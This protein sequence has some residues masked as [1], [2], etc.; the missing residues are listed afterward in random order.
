M[1]RITLSLL[2]CLPALA[3]AQVEYT[4]TINDLGEEVRVDV[5][6]PTAS[7]QAYLDSDFLR[8]VEQADA[9]G[10]SFDYFE[11][12]GQAVFRFHPQGNNHPT[13]APAEGGRGLVAPNHNL[14]GG[15][16]DTCG[17]DTLE[18]P[19]FGKATALQLWQIDGSGYVGF[20]QY[21]DAPQPVIVHGVKVYGHVMN[22]SSNSDTVT[23][24]VN[25]FDA[26][27]AD[28]M[29]NGTALATTTIDMVKAWNGNNIEDGAYVAT[30]SQPV[31]VNS[32]Y[33]VS[34]EYTGADTVITLSNSVNNSDGAG[35]NLGFYN[36][37][38]VWYRNIDFISFDADWIQHPIVEY[39][40]KADF[41]LSPDS[42]CVSDTLCTINMSDS[43]YW[44]RM[45]NQDDPNQNYL[46]DWGD[47]NT[48]QIIEA[49][50]IY[51]SPGDYTISLT[52]TLTGWQITCPNTQTKTMH[53]GA[54][55]VADFTFVI[56]NATG[57]VD[58][59][60]ASTGNPDSWA[61]DFGDFAGTSSNQ[62]PSYTYTNGGIYNAWLIVSNGCGVDTVTENI[63]LTTGVEELDVAIPVTVFPNPATGWV[64]VRNDGAEPLELIVFDVAG[65]I[66]A[67]QSIPA[68]KMSN[69]RVGN[70]AQGT[71]Y[72][73]FRSDDAVE[74]KRLQ[75]I[76]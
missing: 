50:H 10:A 39:Q 63:T 26:N 22:N 61:W 13:A 8:N 49:C 41:I 64:N 7:G 42:M 40:F 17:V 55:P 57:V 5:L 58:F 43:A 32:A 6:R 23:V 25:L 46:W 30:F 74:T 52:E 24:T 1:K 60:D 34:M 36:Y 38:N 59:T 18:Y 51:A 15:F 54:P 71:Y 21:Y 47:G 4:S 70:W 27:P 11:T 35:E 3:F 37:Q 62:D 66:V 65:A 44:N 31:T 9:T 33:F 29:P 67:R 19:L 12:A 75:V 72:L 53:V 14:R 73:R 16:S 20:G 76:H 28:S 56:D 69:L 68:I 45:Y 2:A 48:S